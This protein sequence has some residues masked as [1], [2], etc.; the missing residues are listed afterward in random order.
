MRTECPKCGCVDVLLDYGYSR[1]GHINSH[2]NLEVVTLSNPKA[3]LRV[4]NCK[5]CDYVFK[6]SDF[7]EVVNTLW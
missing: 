3:E 1:S 6:E 7:N 5:D 4:I 2:G